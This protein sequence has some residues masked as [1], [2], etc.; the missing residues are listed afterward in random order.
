MAMNKEKRVK[1]KNKLF[2]GMFIL[3]LILIMVSVSFS[4]FTAGEKAEANGIH[5]SATEGESLVLKLGEQEEGTDYMTFDFDNENPLVPVSGNG[6]YF[7]NAILGYKEVQTPSGDSVIVKK[8][9]VGY[10]TV[11]LEDGLKS[12]A[13]AGICAHDFIMYPGADDTEVYLYRN[14]SKET[15]T[16]TCGVS[17]TPGDKSAYGDFDTG[18]ICGAIRIGLLKKDTETGEY[19][20]TFIWAPSTAIEL[21]EDEEGKLSIVDDPEL[22]NYEE[23]YLYLGESSENEIVVSTGS[24]PRSGSTVIDGVTYAWGDINNKIKIADLDGGVNNNFRLVIWVDGNDRECHNALMDG[25]ITVALH[26]GL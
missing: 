8:D 18:N 22:V 24:T 11:N 19:E 20:P 6:K 13:Q 5:M 1:I 17:Y 14:S 23:E 25:L 4:W 10:T 12:Y 2:T 26:F 15:L 21:V 3:S 9:V 16:M 7:Y